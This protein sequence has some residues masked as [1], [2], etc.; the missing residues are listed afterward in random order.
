[1]SLVFV[2]PHM[3]GFVLAGG[4]SS[5]MGAD[6]ALQLLAGQPLINHA[7]GALRQAGLT[8]AIAGAHSPLSE[9]A[10][11]IEDKHPGSGPL[12]GVCAALASTPA[13]R[14]LF[15]SVDTPL[16]PSSLLACLAHH[17]QITQ[18]AVTLC[19]VNGFAQTFPAVVSRESLPWLQRELAEGRGG[20]YAA[21]QTA[22]A[23]LG[24]L[25]KVLPVEL[26]AQTGSVTHPAGLPAAFWLLNVN[27]PADLVRAGQ[28]L[29]RELRVS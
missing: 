14:F 17:A 3:A 20:C 8:A 25:L 2:P 24:R 7:L 22:A 9:F 18:A 1:M 10:P 26:L 28:L 11:V 29:D 21:F 16:L 6:K 4:Q 15:V 19:S 12:G 23:R 5:R 13:S 27:R